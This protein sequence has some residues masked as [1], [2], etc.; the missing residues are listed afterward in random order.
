MEDDLDKLLPHPLDEDEVHDLALEFVEQEVGRFDFK[1]NWG[2][3]KMEPENLRGRLIWW[4]RR[5]KAPMKP[6][7]IITHLDQ[8]AQR[9]GH[10]RW[11]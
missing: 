9:I 8:L 5:M 1:N 6:D 7:V 2:K 10:S 11:R 3:L 4:L